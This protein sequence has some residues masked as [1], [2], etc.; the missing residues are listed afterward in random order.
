MRRVHLVVKVAVEVEDRAMLRADKRTGRT[1]ATIDGLLCNFATW[2]ECVGAEP[3]GTFEPDA[4]RVVDTTV[5]YRADL[6]PVKLKRRRT[7]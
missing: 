6:E 4:Y 5:Y 7:T 1:R 3:G 2:L